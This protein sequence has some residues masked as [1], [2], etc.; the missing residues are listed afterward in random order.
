MEGTLSQDVS[1]FGLRRCRYVGMAMAHLQ[2]VTTA[3]VISIYRVSDWL[4]AS[5]ERRH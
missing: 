2:H 5:R 1:G 3:A 4:G